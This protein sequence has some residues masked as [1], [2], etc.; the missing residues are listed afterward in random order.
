MLPRQA[1]RPDR[2]GV[3]EHITSSSN[4]R[5]KSLRRWHTR[6]RRDR[7]NVV[8][9]EGED[10]VSAAIDAS[11]ALR[12][13]LV[14]AERSEAIHGLLDRVDPSRVC[15]ASNELIASVSDLA[16]PPRVIGVFDRPAEPEHVP[17]GMARIVLDA[18]HDPGNVGTAIRSATALGAAVVL[19]PG[20]GDPWSGKALRAAMGATFRAVVMRSSS[21]AEACA[22]S[23]QIIALAADADQPVWGI[24]LDSSSAFIVGSERNGISDDSGAIATARAMIPFAD[25]HSDSLNAGVAASL[26]LYEWSR[27]QSREDE[28]A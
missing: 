3:F 17:E 12:F 11:C 28:N 5:L 4:T 1:S 21:C 18:V 2:P 8:V 13:I 22:G 10:L 25:A 24:Q 27:Q 7:D 26:A 16:H 6:S 15:S 9:V 19:L 23:D 14:D 20:C